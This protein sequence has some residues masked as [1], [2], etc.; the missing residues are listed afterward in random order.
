MTTNVTNHTRAG[1]AGKHIQCPE[2]GAAS[3]VYHFAWSAMK[4]QGCGAYPQKLSW[5]VSTEQ[6]RVNA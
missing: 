6:N 1:A 2:C 3:T 4:C 5:L